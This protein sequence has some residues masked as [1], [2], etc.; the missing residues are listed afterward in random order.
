M[1]HGGTACCIL[2]ERSEE[3][4]TTGPLSTKEDV[5]AHQNCLLYSAGIFCS[6]TPQFDDLFGFSVSDVKRE[7]KRGRKLSCSGCRKRGATSGCEV[8]RCKKSFHYPCAVEREAKLVEDNKNGKYVL[9]CLQHHEEGNRHSVNGSK[10]LSKSLKKLRESR[11]P[12]RRLT[13]TEMKEGESPNKNNKK[14]NMIT[15]DDSSDSDVEDLIPPLESD[16][17]ESG[18]LLSQQQSSDPQFN[19]KDSGSFFGSP[20]GNQGKIVTADVNNED[21]AALSSD[22]ESESLLRSVPNHVIFQSNVDTPTQLKHSAVYWVEK[23]V[24]TIKKELDDFTT[25]QNPKKHT[26]EPPVPKQSLAEPT[27]SPPP[28]TSSPVTVAVCEPDSVVLLSSP[29]PPLPQAPVPDQPPPP[30]Q[31]PPSHPSPSPPQTPAS[32]QPHFHPQ[33]PSSDPAASINS[34]SFWR[35]CNA[36]SCT[37]TIFSEFNKEMNEISSRIMADRAT[38]DDY[39]RALSVMMASGKLADFVSR[40][41]EELQRKQVELQKE[42]AAM[43][44]V[45]FALRK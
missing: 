7:V 17:D 35:N 19:S 37:Q 9:Y 6:D 40:Q 15:S 24:Q 1:S 22:A 2:C 30:P 3:T 14:W 33:A 42:A 36:A 29:S 45:V 12:K 31:A 16:L 26:T 34:A 32:D 41:Q 21:N 8:R 25:E 44:D 20:A 13:F 27:P 39:D 28:H 43:K 38:Q 23:S 18:Q 11:P 5:T 4:K 10:R